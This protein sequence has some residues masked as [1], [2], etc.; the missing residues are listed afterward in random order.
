MKVAHHNSS[1]VIQLR[2]NALCNRK[3]ELQQEMELLT[4]QIAQERINLEQ[5]KNPLKLTITEHAVQ[6]FAQ[7]IMK[8]P[9][10]KI[11]AILSQPEL[12]DKY[13]A[14]GDGKY[15]LKGMKH[16]TCVVNSGI[17]VTCYDNRVKDYILLLELARQYIHYRI[18]SMFSNDDITLG[19]FIRDNSQPPHL[20]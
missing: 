7:R 14:K 1:W 2:I 17:I 3:Y 12:L 11:R 6:R 18:D 13:L 4:E 9:N 19:Q 8:L 20:T 5:A 16:V 10:A 15:R